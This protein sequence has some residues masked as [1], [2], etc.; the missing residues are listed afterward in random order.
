MHDA[1]HMSHL[2]G[3][4]SARAAPT[5]SGSDATLVQ[6]ETAQPQLRPDSDARALRWA[7]GLLVLGALLAV[8]PL[9]APML[10][11]VWGAVLVAPLHRWLVHKIHRRKRAAGLAT[12]LLVTAFLAPLVVATLSLSA[13]AVELGQ[14]LSESKSGTEALRA[15]V[16]G[17]GEPVDLRSLDVQQAI[18]LARRHGTSALG[19]AKLLFGTITAVVVGAVVFVAGFYELLV[20]GRR[21]YDWLLERSPLTRPHHHRL[22]N[23]VAEVGRGLL[24]GVGLTAVLQGGAATVGYLFTGVPQPLVLGLVTVFAA[25]IP[26]VGAGLVWAPVTLGLTLSG[27][28]GAALAMLAVGLFVSTFDNLLRPML[29]RHAQLRLPGLLLFISMLGG[30]VVFGGFGLFL[31]PLLVRLASEGLS[32]LKE[33]QEK[34][35]RRQAAGFLTDEA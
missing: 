2:A 29:S 19:A 6:P 9:W 4:T 7:V 33:Q 31:G 11:A 22:A 13:G 15:L 1:E 18:N 25:F 28:T 8:A 17:G 26:S 3:K 5:P 21:A 30:L 32:I 24:I 12:V 20:N 27:R 23:V 34:D 10:F 14:R 16:S 35:A